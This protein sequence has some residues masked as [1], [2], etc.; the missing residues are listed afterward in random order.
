M[1]EI[2]FGVDGIDEYEQLYISTTMHPRFPH[3]LPYLT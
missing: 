3:F 1:F 2:R